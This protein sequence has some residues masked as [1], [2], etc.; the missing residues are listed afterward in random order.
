MSECV[1]VWLAVNGVCVFGCEWCVVR[2]CV[3]VW[4]AVNGVC[5]WCVCGW[6]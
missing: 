4:L 5:V 1:F 2:M 3:C 6:L